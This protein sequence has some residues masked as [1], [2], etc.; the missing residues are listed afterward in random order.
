MHPGTAERAEILNRFMRGEIDAPTAVRQMKLLPP[1][2][3]D[4]YVA[5]GD[6]EFS[7]EYLKAKLAELRGAAEADAS[8]PAA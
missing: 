5:W 3:L 7:E 6:G 4:E 1:R 8:G 2:Q